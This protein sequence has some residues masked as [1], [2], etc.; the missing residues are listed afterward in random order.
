MPEF[1]FVPFFFTGEVVRKYKSGPEFGVFLR[2][3]EISQSV[4]AWSFKI[5]VMKTSVLR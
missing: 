1:F 3:I 2:G 5:N 4:Q